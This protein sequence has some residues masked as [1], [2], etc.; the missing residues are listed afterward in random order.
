MIDADTRILDQISQKV[1]I[2]RAKLEQRDDQLAD[3]V[4]LVHQRAAQNGEYVCQS[5]SSSRS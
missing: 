2:A 4:G 5:G 1:M 3:I